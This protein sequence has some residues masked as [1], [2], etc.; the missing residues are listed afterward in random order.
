METREE[1]SRNK[2]AALGQSPG[3]PSRDIYNNIFELFCRY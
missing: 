3:S 2:S 1:K